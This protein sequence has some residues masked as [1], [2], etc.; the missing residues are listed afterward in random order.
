M[1][2]G[3]SSSLNRAAI[4]REMSLR[5]HVSDSPT[6]P[7]TKRR[8]VLCTT[9]EAGCMKHGPLRPPPGAWCCTPLTQT[10]IGAPTPFSHLLISWGG[11]RAKWGTDTEPVL[12]LLEKSPIVVHTL[13]GFVVTTKPKTALEGF[14]SAF[15]RNVILKMKMAYPFLK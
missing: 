15:F 9:T 1:R 2:L 12:L 11:E 5:A 13:N 8:G 6:A 7:P 4:Q 14:L 3:R 10:H